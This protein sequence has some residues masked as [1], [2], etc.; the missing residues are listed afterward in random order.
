MRL[1]MLLF[2]LSYE[3]VIAQE[4]IEEGECPELV[5]VEWMRDEID[6]VSNWQSNVFWSGVVSSDTTFFPIECH[7]IFIA[8]VPEY[9]CEMTPFGIAPT[10]YQSDCSAKQHKR[11][12]FGRRFCHDYRLKIKQPILAGP[13]I[14]IQAS[15]ISSESAHNYNFLLADNGTVLSVATSWVI[16]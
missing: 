2:I 6:R 13:F 10:L 9:R 11:T 5:V 15:I 16:W 1:L 7:Q 8:E 14:Y 4:S 12:S 3:M